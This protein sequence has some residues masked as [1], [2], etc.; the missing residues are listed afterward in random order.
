MGMINTVKRIRPHDKYTQQQKRAEKTRCC[1]FLLG[2]EVKRRKQ[3]QQPNVSF[4]WDFTA[5]SKKHG[6]IDGILT[7]AEGKAR[8]GEDSTTWNGLYNKEYTSSTEHH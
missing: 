8:M 6:Q 7:H 1:R 3:K 4:T 5:R 2:A